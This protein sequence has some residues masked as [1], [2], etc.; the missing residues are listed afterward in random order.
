[1]S[2][3]AAVEAYTGEKFGSEGT[4]TA[5]RLVADAVQAVEQITN[6]GLTL[7]VLEDQL[8][9]QRWAESAFNRDSLFAYSAVGCTGLDTVPLAGDA[10]AGQLKRILSDV[11]A[12]ATKCNIPVM[13]RVLPIAGKKAGDATSFKSTYLFDTMI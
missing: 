4:L 11:A 1:M 9:A 10:T 5:L 8:L 3:A 12:L 6:T 13:A 7:S 2:I